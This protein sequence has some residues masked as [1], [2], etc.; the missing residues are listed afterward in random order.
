MNITIHHRDP[1]TFDAWESLC[2]KFPRCA[3]DGLLVQ[4]TDHD[5]PGKGVRW[6][7]LVAMRYREFPPALVLAP[8]IGCAVWWLREH[9]H[10][11]L[12]NEYR[13]AVSDVL[14]GKVMP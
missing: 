14:Y 11:L 9:H 6:G 5:E 4:Y 8:Q 13:E 7:I 1:L 10:A 2:A 3:I 12:D